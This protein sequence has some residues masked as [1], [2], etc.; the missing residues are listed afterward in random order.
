MNTV[1]S[2]SA[3]AAQNPQAASGRKK[4]ALTQVDFLKLFTKQLQFQNPLAP[5]DNSQMAAQMAQLSTVQAL[6]DLTKSMQNLEAYQASASSLQAVGLIGKKV[7][8]AGNT[9]H[10]GQDNTVSGGSYQLAKPG[11]AY[12]QIF[13]ANGNTVRV[14]DD[15]VKD[16]SKQKLTWDGKNQQGAALPAGNYR[17]KVSAVDERNQPIQA[18]TSKIATVTGISFENGII[19]LNLGSDRITMSDLIAIQA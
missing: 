15:G 11:R 18:T 1:S 16:T 14:L 2:A 3:A 6:G 7:E 9:L 17:F 10:I 4:T 8:A 12:I 13:D 5:M 19:Y